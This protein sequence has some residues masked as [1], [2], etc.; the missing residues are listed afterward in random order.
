M[1]MENK[2]VFISDILQVSY[3]RW[4]YYENCGQCKI[5]VLILLFLHFIY[6]N[7]FHTS[8]LDIL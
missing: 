5:I 1:L 2:S 7:I 6:S 4:Y 8:V 3:V